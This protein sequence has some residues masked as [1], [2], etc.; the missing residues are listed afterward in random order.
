MAILKLSALGSL[1]VRNN[2][3]TQ[4]KVGRLE[5]QV[6]SLQLQQER[7]EQNE[8]DLTSRLIFLLFNFLRN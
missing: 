7:S 1:V 6:K 4:T 2:E 5:A 8:R 3:E